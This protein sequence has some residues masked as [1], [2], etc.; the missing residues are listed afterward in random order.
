MA[1]TIMIST[2]VKPDLSEVLIVIL[3]LLA[4]LF[5]RREPNNRRVNI[6]TAFVH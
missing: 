2:R 6:I 4:F 1:T 3:A 5:V